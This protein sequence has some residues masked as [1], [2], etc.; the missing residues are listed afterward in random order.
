LQYAIRT[1]LTG[2]T[3][4]VIAH[5]LSTIREADQIIVLRDGRVVEQGNHTSLLDAGG[6]YAEMWQQQVRRSEETHETKE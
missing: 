6:E 5:R 3:A 1:A 2:R 4:L